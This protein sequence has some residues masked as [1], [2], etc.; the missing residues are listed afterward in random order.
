[1]T[2]IDLDT[3]ELD[4]L[5]KLRKEVDRAI[6]TFEARRKAE[7]RDRLDEMAREMGFSL[8]ELSEAAPGRKRVKS[9]PKY[10]NPVDPSQTWSGRGRRPYW[11]AEA[12]AKGHDLDSMLIGR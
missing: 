7:A 2:Q 11:V 1:M 8:N 6:Q 12:E 3:L 10:A 5:K 4:E 9:P